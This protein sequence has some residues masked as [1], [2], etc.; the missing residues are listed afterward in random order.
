M[1]IA[2]VGAGAIG[3]W[4]GGLLAQR[5][6]E[7]HLVTRRDAAFITINGLTLKT[8]DTS[9]LVQVAS[10]VMTTQ[11][12]GLCDL[13]VVATKSTAN[14][15][16]PALLRP[17]LGPKTVL[18]TLQNG[19]GNVEFLSQIHPASLIV[20]GL[21]F[22]C[23]NR[24]APG[25]IDTQLAGYVR[26][27]AAQGPCNAVVETCVSIFK[28]AGVECESDDSLEGILWRKLC[29]NIP[30][31]GLSIAAGGVTTDKILASPMLA[32]RAL[33]LMS[34]VSAAAAAR[35][36]PFKA[37]H[38]PSQFKVTETM[39][40]YRPSSLIDY[41]EGREVEVEGIWGEPL[42]RGELAGISM[43]ELQ[44]LKAEILAKLSFRKP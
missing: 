38:I 23:I 21:C 22:V 41:L 19:M 32:E 15:S 8:G 13:V 11:P 2:I 4:Y 31:N 24:I 35:G 33:K 6:H 34:E 14:G 40:A 37:S 39:G 1:K 25:V 7:V 29:W 12:I 44:A 43:P 20:G 36:H 27:A 10:A 5:G 16:L 17:V 42:R 30:F 9:K 18:L 3:G 28:D 26:M